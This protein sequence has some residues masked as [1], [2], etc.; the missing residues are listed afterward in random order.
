ML[1]LKRDG[2]ELHRKD[3]AHVLSFNLLSAQLQDSAHYQCEATNQHG[4]EKDGLNL[5][6]RG[7]REIIIKRSMALCSEWKELWCIPTP[8]VNYSRVK[9][10][11]L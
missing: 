2:V 3:S 5:T 8:D 11:I 7:K 9:R 1:V 6:V 10:S 4:A